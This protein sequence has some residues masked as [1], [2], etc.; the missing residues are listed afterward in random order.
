VSASAWPRGTAT[1]G[2]RTASVAGATALSIHR[3]SG[4]TA[5]ISSMPSGPTVKNSATGMARPGAPSSS[6]SYRTAT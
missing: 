6:N 2:A 1:R 4:N 5:A 3:L